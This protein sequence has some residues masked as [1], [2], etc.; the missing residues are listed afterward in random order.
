MPEKEWTV[1]DV[2]LFYIADARKK[3]KNP[4][5][6]E[7]ALQAAE[8]NILPELG[9][10]PVPRLTWTRITKWHH[11]LAS[12]GRRKTG[13]KRGPGEEVV[14][15][16]LDLTDQI[17]V[18]KRKSSANRDLALLK[19]ALGFAVKQNM[20]D[21]EHTP[22]QT[23]MPFPGVT[24][25]R[26]RFLSV[27]EQQKLV[28][29]CDPEFRLLV[30]GALLTGVRYQELAT[31]LVRDYDPASSAV[32]VEGKGQDTRVRWV[33]LTEEGDQFFRDLVKGRD[34]D[35]WMFV[36][37]DVK[38]TTRGDSARSGGWMP[39]DAKTP[40]RLA[41]KQAG[42][43]PMTFHELRHTYASMLILKGMS[44]KMV[45][46]QLGHVD[47]RMVEKH[48]GHLAPSARRD[49]MREMRGVQLNILHRKPKSV[50]GVSEEQHIWG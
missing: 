19:G 8:A 48:Y 13:K 16:P 46:D 7:M 1:R 28:G 17:A 23:V 5:N 12:R 2:I 32:R 21:P 40:L 3:R 45:A 26:V 9:D 20:I 36:R 39:D 49:A 47:T 43:E 24:G 18:N 34:K 25:S 4:E 29:A 44:L 27:D 41:L 31:I 11:A 38:R 10:I 15:A 37:K 14:Y 50:C 42:I 30:C 35:E 33:Y 22:W 6:A